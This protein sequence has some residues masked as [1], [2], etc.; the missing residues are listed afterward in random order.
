MCTLQQ[1]FN[2]SG[3]VM[4]LI[5][6]ITSPPPLSPMLCQISLKQMLHHLKLCSSGWSS[7]VCDPFS[8]TQRKVLIVQCASTLNIFLA[9]ACVQCSN[10]A[11]LQLPKFSLCTEFPCEQ[12][13]KAENK[14]TKEKETSKA[15]PNEAAWRRGDNSPTPTPSQKQSASCSFSKPGWWLRSADPTHAA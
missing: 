11:E 4:C 2:I 14:G 13:R 1:M 10:N 6:I 9:S 3:G 5:N 7:V 15:I 12:Q 8:N